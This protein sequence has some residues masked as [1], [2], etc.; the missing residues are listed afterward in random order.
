MPSINHWWLPDETEY[1]RII[2]AIR[3]FIQ[4][5][6]TKPR[7]QVTEDI[8][9]M[10]AIF[11]NFNMD[12]SPKDSPES[13]DSLGEPPER[14]TVQGATSYYNASG[15]SS[16]EPSTGPHIDQLGFQKGLTA[17]VSPDPQEYGQEGFARPHDVSM[18]EFEAWGQG[19]SIEHYERF[20]HNQY[21][22]P[23]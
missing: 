3:A 11:S 18:E 21:Q 15:K 5:R 13:A 23:S 6:T 9:A 19:E 12:D 22:G 8:R 17:S 7:S 16:S 2:R 20:H 10:R 14:S 1:P 4:E